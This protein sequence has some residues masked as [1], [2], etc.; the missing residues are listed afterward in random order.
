MS[1]T[2]A[3]ARAGTSSLEALSSCCCTYGPAW[4]ADTWGVSV[5]VLL[6]PV[7]VANRLV[8]AAAC[9]IGCVCEPGLV[10]MPSALK[11]WLGSGAGTW[12]TLGCPPSCK[13]A[14]ELASWSAMGEATG[15]AGMPHEV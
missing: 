9:A 15:A 8:R 13:L 12:R 2:G 6:A 3:G 5:T 1:G 10:P 11:V 4:V 7:L 14:M